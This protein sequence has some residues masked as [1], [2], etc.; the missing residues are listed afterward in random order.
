MALKTLLFISLLT[1]TFLFADTSSTDAEF[2]GEAKAKITFL[3]KQN[4]ELKAKLDSLED[5]QKSVEEYKAIIDR[6][7]KRVEDVNAKMAWAAEKSS[8]LANIIGIW[9]I[10]ATFISIGLPL[11]LTFKW[12]KEV[13]EEAKETAQI[14][15]NELKDE[16]ELTVQKAKDELHQITETHNY[17]IKEK[18]LMKDKDVSKYS[19]TNGGDIE[20]LKGAFQYALYQAEMN[21]DYSNWFDAAMLASKL[22]D[23]KSI[24]YWDNALKVVQN[25]VSRVRSLINKAMTLGELNYENKEIEIYNNILQKYSNSEDNNIQ[26][27]IADTL[28]KKGY[29]LGEMKKQDDAISVYD[30]LFKK[31]AN[32]TNE[33]IK[34]NLAIAHT[35]KAIELSDKGQENLA[36]LEYLEAI[37]YNAD[38][39]DACLNLFELQLIQNQEWDIN[40]VK[41][42]LESIKNNKQENLEFKMLQTV[43]NALQEDQTYNIEQLKDEFSDID[44]GDW[45]W[46]ELKIWAEKLEDAKVKARVQQTI[47]V[48]ENWNKKE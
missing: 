40:L 23:P 2:R 31:Y 37:R 6:Q 46:K 43:K 27:S 33:A 38:C 7:D 34:E 4:A 24:D 41:Q 26:E 11:Y 20:G 5:K 10:M 36:I 13:T 17:Y 48:F 19:K 47:E 32:T 28:L 21:N 18:E 45:S 44:F 1:F 30:E 14:E 3:E 12:K 8:S 42:Y 9:A 29:R 25:D 16:F 39:I 35:N 22:K 15:I